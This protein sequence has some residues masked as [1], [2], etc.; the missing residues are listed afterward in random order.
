MK[1]IDILAFAAH[2]DDAEI[3]CGGSLIL[4]ANQGLR[5]A[6]A[7]LSA[8]EMSSRGNP[9]LRAQE[10]ADATKR[11]GL[12]ARYSLALP[13]GYL[14]TEPAHRAPII[15]LIRQTKPRIVLAPY[16]VDRHPDHEATGKLVR[17]AC[18][19]AGVHKMGQGE[20]HRPQ[21]FY[22]YMIHHPFTPSFV[23]DISAV[24]ERKL[25]AIMAYASQF[26]STN[27]ADE[28]QT[29][30]SDSR[31][32]RFL[33]AKA[34]WFGAMIGVSYGEPFFSHAPVHLAHFPS[35]ADAPQATGLPA[36][37]MSL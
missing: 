12:C 25:A 14:G 15:D 11:L 24:W 34:I 37:K 22:Y 35:S 5:V 2:P 31:F 19:F 18:F 28:P 20:P 17:E 13:D 27:T 4:A 26:Q 30:L 8:G 7:D 32:T 29:A 1:S 23:I 10:T 36:Y 21:H 33:E 3:G 6:V 9:T 16:Y